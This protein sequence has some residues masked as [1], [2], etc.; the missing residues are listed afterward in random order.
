M[1]TAPPPPTGLYPMTGAEETMGRKKDIIPDLT[2][3]RGD[4][5]QCV[6]SAGVGDRRIILSQELGGGGVGAVLIVIA[7]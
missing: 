4:D 6:L 7:L 5:I 1:H 2:R 3:Q